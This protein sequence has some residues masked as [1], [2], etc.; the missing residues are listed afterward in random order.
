MTLYIKDREEI[1]RRDRDERG[2]CPPHGLCPQS[3]LQALYGF[4]PLL[5]I[6]F[7]QSEESLSLLKQKIK[8]LK[9]LNQ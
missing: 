4:V 3:R 8:R 9:D 1:K 7:L 5:L 6:F 2:I